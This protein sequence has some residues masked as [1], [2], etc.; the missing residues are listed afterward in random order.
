ML[1]STRD[2]RLQKIILCSLSVYVYNVGVSDCSV[3]EDLHLMMRS[4]EDFTEDSYKTVSV[5]PLIT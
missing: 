1:H 5:Q 4:A 3:K 2:G